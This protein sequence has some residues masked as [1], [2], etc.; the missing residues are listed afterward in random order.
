MFMRLKQKILRFALRSLLPSWAPLEQVIKVHV[1]DPQRSQILHMINENRSLFQ[2]VRGSTN[3]H[4][5]WPG[6]WSDHYADGMNLAVVLYTVLDCLRPLPFSLHDVLVS[7]FAHDI[8][9]PWKYDYDASTG[10][11]N[12]K[13]NFVTKEDA[14]NFR[15]KK[16]EEY[17]IVLTPM[18]LNGME[19]AEGEVGK[20]YSNRERKSSPLA[21]VVHAVDGLSARLWYDCPYQENDP[22]S[23]AFRVQSI[24][25]P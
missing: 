10:E 8:E 7:F 22:W 21:S 25:K 19:Y 4:Q 2:E 23:G 6:G 9:K 12:H 18:Q 14:N 16:L 1:N 3:N 20:L 11:W 5:A 24:N 13:A 15:I 17:G